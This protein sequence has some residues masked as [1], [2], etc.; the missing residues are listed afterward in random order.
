MFSAVSCHSGQFAWRSVDSQSVVA[1]VSLHGGQLFWWSVGGGQLTL[2]QLGAVSWGRSVVVYR[3]VEDNHDC[4]VHSTILLYY[5]Y[6]A[7]VF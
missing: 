6:D 2:D 5:M 1:A 7:H 3:R 4:K